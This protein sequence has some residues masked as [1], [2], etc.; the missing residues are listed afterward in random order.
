M[1]FADRRESLLT[2]SG[3]YLLAAADGAVGPDQVRAELGDVLAGTAPGRA[4]DDEI[5]IFESLGLAIED[6]AA[7]AC[8]HRKAVGTRGTAD[9]IG[10]WVSF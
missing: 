9:E 1:L 8:A 6:L 5:T 4:N 7:A 2:E 3:D 10:R